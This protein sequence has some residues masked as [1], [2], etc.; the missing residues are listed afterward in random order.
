[1]S[2]VREQTGAFAWDY[3]DIRG[4][5]PDTCIH[6]IYTNEEMGPVRQ[7]QRRMNPA[8]KD[9]VKDEL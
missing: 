9:I 3:L 5:H 2:M 1:M 6:H 4:I 7:L 8:L